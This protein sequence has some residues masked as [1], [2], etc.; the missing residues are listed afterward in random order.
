MRKLFIL[1]MLAALLPAVAIAENPYPHTQDTAVVTGEKGWNMFCRQDS[2]PSADSTD[3]DH[4]I[5]VCTSTGALLV[6]AAA[7]GVGSDTELPAAAALGDNVANPTVPGVGAFLMCWDGATWDRCGTA[8]AVV[9]GGVEATALRVTIASDSTGVLSIDDNAGSLTVDNAQLSVVGGG[10]E[11]TAL[12]V[13]LANDSTGVVSVDDNGAAL[14]IDSTQLPAALGAGAEAGAMLVTLATDSTGL[15]SVDDNGASLTVDGTVAITGPPAAT[16]GAGVAGQAADFAVLG[17]VANQR[18]TKLSI[19]DT[20]AG[21]AAGI[22]RHATLGANCDA[23]AVIAY[24]GVLGAAATYN[25]D[26]GSRDLAVG[27]GVCVDVT[28]GTMSAAW[29]S[30]VE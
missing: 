11:A 10:A 13:T 12:R 24:F 6:S 4:T 1:V 2:T 20:G 22:V 18:L 9:G 28:A 25:L 27:S 19:L 26:V 3:G 21:T 5:P 29:A 7:G 16:V 14:T 30:I 23:G 15:V 17:T 8:L